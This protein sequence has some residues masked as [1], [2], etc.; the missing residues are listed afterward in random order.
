MNLGKAVAM[1]FFVF[2]W[3]EMWRE[4]RDVSGDSKNTRRLAM[5]EYARDLDD[6]GIVLQQDGQPVALHHVA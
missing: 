6:L 5:R 1:V 4:K 3:R 2:L